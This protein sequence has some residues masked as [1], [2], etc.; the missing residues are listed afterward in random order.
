MTINIPASASLEAEN[1]IARRNTLIYAVCQAL[2]NSSSIVNISLGGLAGFY[3]LDADKSLATAPVTGFNIGVALGAIP[4]AMM[5]K[6]LGRRYG[7]MFGLIVGIIG[8]LISAKALIDQNFILFCFGAILSGVAGGF[9]QQYRFAAADHG[10]PSLRAKSISWVLVGGIVAAFIGSPLIIFTRDLLLPTH[11]AGAYLSV[12]ALLLIAM[13]V[14]GFLNTTKSTVDA[15]VESHTP[16]RPLR[17]IMAQ[18]RFKVAVLCGTLTYALMSLVMTGAPLAMVGCGISVDNATLGIQWH[19][20][21]MFGPSFFTGNLIARFGKE[22]IVAVGMLL[23]I[24]CAI[25][26]LGGLNLM[27]FWGAL[28]LLGLGWNFGFIGATSMI[29]DTYTPSEKNKAQGANDLILFSTVAFS[30]L[31]SGI[32]YNSYGWDALV[33]IIFPVVALAL[34]ALAWLLMLEKK[35]AVA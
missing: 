22:R 29:T 8:L 27:N 2:G 13:A 11:F 3:L 14:L 30:S 32:V 31:M 7:F 34:A 19:V 21:A 9:G 6:W 25:V 28:V 12:S 16:P 35:Q 18:P 17:E 23:L 15:E 4:A 33:Y 1:I 20:L 10:S 24:G 5:T 26:A